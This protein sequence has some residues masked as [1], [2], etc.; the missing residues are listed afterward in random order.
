MTRRIF[1]SFDVGTGK[2]RITI[3]MVV[4]S[5]MLLVGSVVVY[6]Y[7]SDTVNVQK[8]EDFKDLVDAQIHEISDKSDIA[9]NY[10]YSLRGVLQSTEKINSVTWNQ[11]IQTSG[12]NERYPGQFSFFYAEVVPKA[13]RNKFESEVLKIEESQQFVNFSI[14]P[15]SE[16]A[17]SYVIR[18]IET[19]NKDVAELLGFDLGTSENL[20]QTM[21]DTANSDKESMSSIVNLGSIVSS[22]K[23]KGYVI[24]LP[25]YSNPQAVNYPSSERKKS[26]K[27]FVGA[28]I[29]PSVLFSVASEEGLNVDNFSLSVNEGDLEVYKYNFSGNTGSLEQIKSVDLVGKKFTLIFKDTKTGTV[30]KFME[31][32][33]IRILVGL[34]ALNFFWYLTL[35]ALGWAKDKA[36]I[37][38]ENTLDDLRKFK[39]A[40]DGVSDL[41][42]ITDG[43]GHILY[44][45]DAAVK[46]T[47]YSRE[48]AIGKTPGLWGMQMDKE[49]YLK[50]WKTIKIEKK[51]FWGEL[52][53]RRKDGEFYEVELRV[54]PIL[55]ENSDIV[56]YVGIERDITK[57]KALEKMK[58]EFISLAS[59]QLRTPLSA[60]KWFSKM[61]IDGEAGKLTKT[62][63]EYVDKVYE[64]NEREIHLI[65][66]LLNVSRIDSGKIAVRNR[67]TNM[68]DLIQSV[69][70]DVEVGLSD[71]KRKIDLHVDDNIPV[72]DIDPD[73]IRHA[74]QNIITNAVRYTKENGKVS[75][76]VDVKNGELVTKISDDGI[77][78][79]KAEQERIF[80]K[81]F[82]AT[83]ALKKETDGNGLGLYLAKTVIESSGG[84]IWFE[85]SEGNGTTFWFTLPI[86]K[87]IV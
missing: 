25:V 15:K 64:S 78:I 48:E 11:Y 8:K 82:R 69:V 50:F 39:Q 44:M 21:I 60:V 51:S 34:I 38:A 20:S 52:K 17:F 45:N 84:K 24:L 58:L 10:I 32:M 85:S 54:W 35:F 59:H 36:Q 83:N 6:L 73:L 28:W 31:T 41:V 46:A 12:V 68:R 76:L 40:V 74:Y 53:N 27:G 47:G 30:P 26:I 7:I 9:K 71:Q 42:V 23:S 29:E 4:S 72:M 87:D 75:I 22:V 70:G 66:S 49:F 19:E 16:N 81:F 3:L 62:Q 1:N 63:K 57:T 18:F 77:G 65:N 79:P 55:N 86:K 13:T 5:L 33:S 67:P 37:L 43:T 61:L 56:F 2:L 14:Y 80:E